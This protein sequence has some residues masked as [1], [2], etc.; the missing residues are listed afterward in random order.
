MKRQSKE[1]SALILISLSMLL[2]G[3]GAAKSHNAVETVVFV[4]HGEKPEK[5]L[6]QLSCRGLNRALACLR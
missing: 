6:G 1:T 4:R 5:G 3:G 2:L